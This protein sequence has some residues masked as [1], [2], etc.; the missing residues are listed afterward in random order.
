[1]GL[2]TSLMENWPDR[3][4]K[5]LEKE[6]NSPSGII[7]IAPQVAWALSASAGVGENFNQTFDA[8]SPTKKQLKLD[9]IK[10]AAPHAS[11]RSSIASTIASSIY[12]ALN[13]A[14]FVTHKMIPYMAVDG[15]VDLAQRFVSCLLF[16]ASKMIGAAAPSAEFCDANGAAIT[17][18]LKSTKRLY[19]I[20]AKL[21]LSFVNNP[22]ALTSKE[23]KCFLGYV[24]ATLM[25]RVSAL[26]L[27]LH[28]KQETSDGKFLA[29][30]K[31][32]SHGKTSALLV[33]EK[34][35]LDNALLKVGAKLKQVGLEEE[36]EWLEEHVVSNLSRDF[37]IKNVEDAKA[38]E[39]PKRKPK[40]ES[41]TGAKKRKVKSEPG[42][43]KKQK[44]KKKR[45]ESEAEDES[46]GEDA[47]E[48]V[49]ESVDAD[50]SID[51]GSDVLDLERLTDDM[52]DD[53][54]DDE[55]EEEESESEEEA[56]F[57]D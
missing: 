36:S 37:K 30:S 9:V 42:V 32:E 40:K 6:S 28:E 31:I 11:E 4:Q 21:M 13:N 57:D 7:G 2:P 48:S 26:L 14:E 16:S 52:Q 49:M 43:E 45:V 39:A 15:S 29:E 55:E 20:L 18:L 10:A 22:E 51:D 19:G 24:V 38:R 27:T 33:F 35:K 23:T 17:N 47:E 56:E 25:P 12:D 41:S 3:H 53:D 34:E 46:E 54:D 44:K 1:M 8:N 50:E 5:R